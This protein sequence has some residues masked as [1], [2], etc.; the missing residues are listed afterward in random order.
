[1]SVEK[2]YLVKW[3]K[4]F[5]SGPLK[6]LFYDSQLSFVNLNDATEYV[7]H[8]HRHR[9]VPVTP[10]AGIDYYICHGARIVKPHC[11]GFDVA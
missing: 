5:T 7:A 2:Y 3:T 10:C 8:L 11:A 1:M 6:G 9:D 4:E